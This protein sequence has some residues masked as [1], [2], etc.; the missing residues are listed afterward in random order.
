MVV[1][2]PALVLLTGTTSSVA[3]L[4]AEVDRVFFL[5]TVIHSP[6]SFC[7]DAF[8]LLADDFAGFLSN[9]P[10]VVLA[11]VADLAG[12]AGF[13]SCDVV[14][15][16]LAVGSLAGFFLTGESFDEPLSFFLLEVVFFVGLVVFLLF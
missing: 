12:A 8:A 2:G 6:S 15:F 13:L 3:F 1:L 5:L 7:C 4:P 9:A 10:L 11:P 16:V 14:L